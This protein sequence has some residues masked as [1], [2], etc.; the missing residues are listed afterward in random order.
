MSVGVLRLDLG[1]L[2]VQLGGARMHLGLVLMQARELRAGG[3]GGF[4]S[5]L[6]LSCPGTPFTLQR[7]LTALDRGGVEVVVDAHGRRIPGGAGGKLGSVRHP[8]TSAR[9]VVSEA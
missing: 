7:I 2:V 3:I 9:V 6:R 4:L 5:G 8:A 1:R